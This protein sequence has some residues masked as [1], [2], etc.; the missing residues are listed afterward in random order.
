MIN[1]TDFERSP[2]NCTSLVSICQF[3]LTKL[4][5]ILTF[6]TKFFNKFKRIPLES[7]LSKASLDTSH[8]SLILEAEVISLRIFGSSD[9]LEPSLKYLFFHDSKHFA[10]LSM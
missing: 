4:R 1:L 8:S 7:A 9:A 2:S 5:I 10:I 6:F 3:W